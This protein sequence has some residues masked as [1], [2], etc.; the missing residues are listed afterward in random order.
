MEREKLDLL[1][2]VIGMSFAIHSNRLRLRTLQ[3]EDLEFLMKIWGDPDVMRF[4]G[5]QSSRTRIE[6]AITGYKKLQDE[7]GYSVYVV[8]LKDSE[9]ALG[10]CGF[11]PT[12]VD[13][14]IELLFHF[15]QKY[16]GKGYAS[17]AAKACINYAQ[18]ELQTE[19]IVAS[20]DPKN[21]AS[22]KVLEKLGL[23]NRGMQWF[24][25]TQQEEVC[26]ELQVK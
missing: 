8:E 21:T 15:V 4:C 5:G 7:K 17:E 24:N 20:A 3:N 22:C 23:D 2:V 19:K 14:E 26:F 9:E 25:D 6:R 16:W 10:V 13:S 11:N 18:N 12:S 1:K